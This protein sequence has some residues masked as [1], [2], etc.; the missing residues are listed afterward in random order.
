MPDVRHRVADQL[1]ALARIL[2]GFDVTPADQEDA[3]LM[4]RLALALRGATEEALLPA[5]AALVYAGRLHR[6]RGQLDV[7]ESWEP[8]F[9]E[10]AAAQALVQR[11]P[12]RYRRQLNCDAALSRET[13]APRRAGQQ[14]PSR[15]ER[16]RPAP[17]FPRPVVEPS[18]G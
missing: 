9:D 4:R 6:L 17:S 15:R 8:T 5:L 18:D 12:D 10:L 1:D 13:L 3:A 14:V 11:L 7:P 2:E 16:P